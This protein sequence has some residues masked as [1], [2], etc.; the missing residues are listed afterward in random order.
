MLSN[1][2]T[3]GR[4][5]FRQTAVVLGDTPS[6]GRR[7]GWEKPPGTLE[8]NLVTSGY[9]AT[10]ICLG[11]PAKRFEVS[12]SIHAHRSTI[13]AHAHAPWD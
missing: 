5:H 12:S 6:Q 2:S 8:G 13:H 7:L 11:T 10:E 3:A 9:F 4:L 1:S